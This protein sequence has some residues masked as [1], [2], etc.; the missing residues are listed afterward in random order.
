MSDNFAYGNGFVAFE[1]KR[2][3]SVAE[4]VVKR[5]GIFIFE[6]D[7]VAESHFHDSFSDTAVH[8]CISREY[9]TACDE[10]MQLC[11]VFDE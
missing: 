4:Y 5:S 1:H 11:V 3:V 9:I 2:A 10:L 6:S 8:W 7:T